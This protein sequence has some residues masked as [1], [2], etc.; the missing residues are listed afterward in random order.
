VEERRGWRLVADQFEDAV[1]M[2]E[3]E[4]ESDDGAGRV[5]EDGGSD[6]RAQMRDEL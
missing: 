3:Q 4:V 6:V 2:V 5:A 1:G